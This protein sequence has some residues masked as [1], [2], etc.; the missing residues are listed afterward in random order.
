MSPL[1]IPLYTDMQ[2]YTLNPFIRLSADLRLLFG[3][4]YWKTVN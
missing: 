2:L 1:K 4:F 3:H